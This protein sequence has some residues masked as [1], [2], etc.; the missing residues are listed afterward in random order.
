MVTGQQL[1]FGKRI[2]VPKLVRLFNKIIA[3]CAIP[4]AWKICKIITIYKGKGDKKDPS[5]YR[6]ITLLSCLSKFFEV[7][8]YNQLYPQINSKLPEFQHGFRRAHSVTTANM[9]ISDYIYTS[10]DNQKIALLV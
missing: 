3:I 10:L 4:N 8:I 7:C 1:K 6:P 5:N 2:L 9:E